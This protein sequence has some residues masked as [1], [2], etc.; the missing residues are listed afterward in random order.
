MIPT[1]TQYAIEIWTADMRLIARTGPA[2][3]AV[4]RADLDAL[5]LG[6][7]MSRLIVRDHPQGEW[8]LA[9]QAPERVE[10]AA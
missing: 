10:V 5:R 7:P 3:E 9:E 6:A 1:G 4:A 8:R 2:T